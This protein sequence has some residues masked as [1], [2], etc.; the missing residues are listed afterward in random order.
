MVSII[1]PTYNGERYIQGSI[2]SVLKQTYQDWELIVI[3]DHSED[4]TGNIVRQ[5]ADKDSRIKL[6]RNE[7]RLLLEQ[8]KV[9]YLDLR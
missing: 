8:R 2:E 1:L 9:S 5:Y 4:G 3:D 6:Y 7:Q